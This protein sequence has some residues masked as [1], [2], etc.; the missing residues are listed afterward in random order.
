MTEI[1]TRRHDCPIC[2]DPVDVPVD[3]MAALAEIPRR[4][5]EALRTA[6][7]R[8]CDGWSSGFIAAHLADLEVSRGWRIR[9]VLTE[10]NPQ[11]EPLDQNALAERLRYGD[12]DIGLALETFAANRAANLELVRM[13]GEAALARS[14]HHPELGARTLGILIDHTA[15][16]DLAHLRQIRA[17]AASP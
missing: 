2:R 17:V 12:R 8:E 4:L 1:E 11:L 9:R 5:R 7:D 15:D 16:H 10:D 6:P 13:A 14:Y 3:A